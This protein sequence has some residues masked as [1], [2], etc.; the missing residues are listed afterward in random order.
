[1]KAVYRNS[2]KTDEKIKNAVIALLAKKQSLNLITVTDTVN[3]AKIN[4]G[5][6]YN[7]YNNVYDVLEDIELDLMDNLT[8][9]INKVD[10]N[11]S[12]EKLVGY[13]NVVNQ[14]LKDKEKVFRNIIPF[15]PKKIQDDF[16]E[17]LVTA[18]TNNQVIIAHISNPIAYDTYLSFFVNG[19]TG[20]YVDYLEGRLNVSLDEI[21]NHILEMIKV[22]TK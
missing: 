16:K 13:V 21:K 12:W 10:E 19:A 22:L 15:I 1:M 8:A 2:L 3:E 18:C 14:F 4:R 11:T 9:I 7:H 5:T 6:F 17:R 20:M